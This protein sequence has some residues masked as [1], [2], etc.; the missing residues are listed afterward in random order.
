MPIEILLIEDNPGDARLLQEHLREAGTD[1]FCLTHLQSLDDGIGQ[2]Q[3]RAKEQRPFDVLLLDLSLSDSSGLKTVHRAQAGAPR[4]PIVVLTGLDDEETG[5]EAVRMGVQDYL[6]KA[7]VDQR[8]ITRAIRY[9]IERKRVEEQ[10]RELNETLEQ[11]VAERTAMAEERASQLRALA[12]ELIQSE[13]RQ[14]RRLAQMLHDQLQQFLIAAKF[15]IGALRSRIADD[16][17]I[18]AVDEIDELLD[19]SVKASKV[20][21]IELSP[22]ILYDAGLVPALEWLARWMREKHGLTTAVDADEEAEPASEDIR[23][24]LFEAVRELLFNIVKHAHI[25][26]ATVLVEKTSDD[27]ITVTVEDTG[28]GFDPIAAQDRRGGGGFGLFSIR[29]RFGLVGGRMDIETA[30]GRGTRVTLRVPGS[31]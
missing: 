30:P 9:A 31:A 1:E 27:Q 29:E 18:Q 13:Q 15:R 23:A 6:I 21:T 5:M 26:E 2:L 25:D 19:E 7:H 8:T 4:I 24:L 12:S 17:Q 11:R 22:P 28:S 16:E 3:A 14:R 20:L 10:L